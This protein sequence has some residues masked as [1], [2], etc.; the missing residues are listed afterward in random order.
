MIDRPRN[1][2]AVEWSQALGLARQSCARVFRDGGKPSDAL[3]LYGLAVSGNEA[4]DWGRAVERIAMALC[5][6]GGHVAQA[7][8]SEASPAPS[9]QPTA[10]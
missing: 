1:L 9:S 3:G 5:G 7:P 10:A 2:N 8:M 6:S 4:A